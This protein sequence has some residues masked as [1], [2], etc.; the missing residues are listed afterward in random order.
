MILNATQIREGM[1][2]VLEGEL[3]RV[4]WTMHRTPGK[5]N[6]VMQTKLK[7]IL[8]G[9]NLEQRFMSAERVEKAD[10]ETRTM[11]YLYPDT[12]GHM[13][14]DNETFEQ[15]TLTADLIGEETS[16]YLT[17]GQGY[18]VTYYNEAPV[19]IELPKSMEFKVESAPPEVKRATATNSQRPVTLERGITVNAPGFIKEGDVIRINTETGEYMER[20]SS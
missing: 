3:Y 20:V 19:G 17:E 8:T 16:K 4:T 11:Q 12:D 15:Y 14:M 13:F 5:G 6:A 1:V 18:S 9:K 10:L 2:L 7:H